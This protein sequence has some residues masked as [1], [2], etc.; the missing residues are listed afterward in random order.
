MKQINP[1]EYVEMRLAAGD[2]PQLYAKTARVK[3]RLGIVGEEIVTKMADG[4]VETVNTV[5]TAD[6]MVVTNPTGEEYIISGETFRKRYEKD[7]AN[8]E[9]Y[10]PKGGA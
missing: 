2:K 10:R 4:H 9:L 8:P 5:K 6:D 7:P 1:K 3:A